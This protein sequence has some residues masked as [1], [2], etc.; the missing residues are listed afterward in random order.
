MKRILLTLAVA[1]ALLIPAAVLA[2]GAGAANPHGD[3]SDP[4]ASCGGSSGG[5][6]TGNCDDQNLPQSEGCLH[7]QAPVQNPHC[8]GTTPETPVTPAGPNTPA[9]GI[10]PVSS[11]TPPAPNTSVAGAEAAGTK[12]AAD[13]GAA[14]AAQQGQAP[15]ELPF[16]GLETLWLVLIGAGML[17]GGLVL[18]GMRTSASDSV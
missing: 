16:T 6:P 12:G 8:Q 17:G 5:K 11:S 2:A 9:S 15:G 7:G 3:K 1:S 10:A 13:P 14:A 4:S 18:R